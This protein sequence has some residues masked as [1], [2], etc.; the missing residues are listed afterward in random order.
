VPDAA[1]RGRTDLFTSTSSDASG[2]F[3][4]NRVPPGDYVAFAFDGVDEGQW[5]DSA[6]LA[7][8]EAQGKRLKLQTAG[9]ATVELIAVSY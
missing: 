8:R 3:R 7:T 1:R 6:Y 4:L 2:R 5:Q 9:S